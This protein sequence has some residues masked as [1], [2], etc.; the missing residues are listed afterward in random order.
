MAPDIS[1]HKGAYTRR[2]SESGHIRKMRKIYGQR[3]SV[4][5]ESLKKTF[6]DSW[7]A[8]GDSAGLHITID[9]H[10]MRFDDAFKTL[11]LQNGLYITPLES[12][13]IV[14]GRRMSKLLLGYGHLEPG[15]ISKGIKLLADI[16]DKK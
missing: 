15:E 4:L 3:R 8:Y 5:L 16:M 13:F 6:C 1:G 9:F 2:A 14:K 12:H 11:C 7:T 10:G